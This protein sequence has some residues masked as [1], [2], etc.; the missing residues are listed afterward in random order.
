V[1]KIE[2]RARPDLSQRDTSWEELNPSKK[3]ITLN[4]KEE[5]AR[6]LARRLIAMS[7]VVV[8]NFSA[9]VMDRLGLGYQQLSALNPGLIMASSSALGRTGPERE[10]VA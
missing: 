4:L 10:R 6:D 3:S 9:G 8:E 7:D 5:P 2:S 1:I